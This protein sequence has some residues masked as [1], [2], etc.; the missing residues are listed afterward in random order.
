MS[1]G[2][3]SGASTTLDPD[4]DDEDASTTVV[5]GFVKHSTVTAA[6]GALFSPGTKING[7][8][9]VTQ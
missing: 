5:S 1:Y 8:P 4:L 9:F 7:D 6:S 2:S 3:Q